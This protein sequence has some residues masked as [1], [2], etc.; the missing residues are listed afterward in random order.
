MQGRSSSS[1]GSGGSSGGHVVMASSVLDVSED[2]GGGDDDDAKLLFNK[3][4]HPVE[5]IDIHASSS[6]R[7][8]NVQTQRWCRDSST[9]S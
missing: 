5:T 4:T 7:G 9:C 2:D 3:N 6:M 1:G 8:G